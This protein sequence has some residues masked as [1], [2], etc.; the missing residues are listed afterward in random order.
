MSE[1]GSPVSDVRMYK[2]LARLQSQNL[3]GKHSRIRADPEVLGSLNI[4]KTLRG[5]QVIID[6]GFSPLP[7]VLQ[8]LLETVHYGRV[9]AEVGEL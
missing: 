9:V 7:F 3:V 4:S 2:Q 5:N 1:G 8:Y 6:H